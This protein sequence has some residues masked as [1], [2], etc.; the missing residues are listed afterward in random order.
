MTT[1]V[2]INRYGTLLPEIPYQF[3]SCKAFCRLGLSG[4]IVSLGGF[5]SAQAIASLSSA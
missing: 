3:E 4:I 5:S 1:G 2:A